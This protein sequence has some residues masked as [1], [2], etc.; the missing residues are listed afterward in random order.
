MAPILAIILVCSLHTLPSPPGHEHEHCSIYHVEMSLGERTMLEAV[1][2]FCEIIE[3]V[4][5]KNKLVVTRCEDITSGEVKPE[6]I[7]VP[8]IKAQQYIMEGLYRDYQKI[9]I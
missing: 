6:I 3:E 9:G 2:Q 1:D 5:T 4:Y 7:S 8:I